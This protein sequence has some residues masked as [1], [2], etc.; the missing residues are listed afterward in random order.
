MVSSLPL[1]TD[2]DIFKSSLDQSLFPGISSSVEVHDGFKGAQSAAALD[3]LAAVQ[4]A[5]STH[6]ATKVTI[7]G[8]SLGISDIFNGEARFNDLPQVQPS[9][10]WTQCSFHFMF[11]AL[12]GKLSPLVC[13]G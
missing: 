11:L 10:F 3:V 5:V 8:H 7:V 1:I 6:S 4:S 9:L 2:I 13:R 12:A